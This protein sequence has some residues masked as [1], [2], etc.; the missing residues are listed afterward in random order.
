MRKERREVTPDDIKDAC[1]FFIEQKLADTRIPSFKDKKKFE[2]AI[3]SVYSKN[4]WWPQEFLLKEKNSITYTNISEKI[5]CVLMSQDV[6][7]TLSEQVY[8][9]KNICTHLRKH[10]IPCLFEWKLQW[11]DTIS[12]LPAPGD[13]RIDFSGS[14]R[15]DMSDPIDDFS[16]WAY[17]LTPDTLRNAVAI[18]KTT[19]LDVHDKKGVYDYPSLR[20]ATQQELRAILDGLRGI[21]R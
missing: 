1:A 6:F 20:I 21:R 5:T 12:L 2:D 14:S 3:A 11:H 18:V 4:S 15:V 13:V 16:I 17:I 8:D 7:V 9:G 19:V 10:G